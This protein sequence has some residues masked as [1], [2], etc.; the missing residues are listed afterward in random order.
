MAPTSPSPSRPAPPAAPRRAAD[1]AAIP[2]VRTVEPLQH[3]F[4][5]VGSDLQDLYGVSP[6][7]I[8]DVT[9]L[10]DAYF[11]AAPPTS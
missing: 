3:R 5:Y 1:L 2:G 4:A 11:R 10:Q 7:H 8:V 6:E 9:A